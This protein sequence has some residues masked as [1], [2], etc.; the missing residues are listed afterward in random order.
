MDE[1]NNFTCVCRGEG[2]IPA[3]INVTWYKEN[4][5]IE[6]VEKERQKL[7]LQNVTEADSGKYYCV[8]E[9]HNGRGDRS[10]EVTVYR[11]YDKLILQYSSIR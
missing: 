6:K 3:N 8:A 10:I 5:Q 4:T 1:G 11:K 7:V 9:G 2:K